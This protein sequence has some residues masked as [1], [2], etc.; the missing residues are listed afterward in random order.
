MADLVKYEAAKVAIAEAK[1]VDEIKLI[2]DNASAIKA[3]A[4]VANDK[5]LEVDASEIRIR[6]ERRLGE[7]I[8][9]QK[10][11]VGL[12]KG[13]QP[14]QSTP[15][16]REGVAPRLEDV[17]IDYKLSSRSQAIAA[18]PEDEFEETLAEHRESQQ[19]VTAKTMETLAKK[20]KEARDPLD[21]IQEVEDQSIT[22]DESVVLFHLKRYWKQ[23]NRKDKNTF[24]EWINEN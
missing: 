10:E 5:Q 13:G 18:I 4:R 8:R 7:M 15:T 2:R 3:A 17:G 6:A 23:A 1:A 19:A 22:G 24:M 16:P 14:Y 20:G 9:H 12:A 11:T 21:T